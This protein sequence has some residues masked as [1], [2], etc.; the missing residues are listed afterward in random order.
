MKAE[1]NRRRRERRSMNKDKANQ[2][3]REYRA[4]NKKERR[5]PVNQNQA[6]R[7]TYGP[8]GEI[9]EVNRRFLVL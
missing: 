7:V 5:D 3:Q 8:H 2:K 6:Q 4:I 9:V 1:R